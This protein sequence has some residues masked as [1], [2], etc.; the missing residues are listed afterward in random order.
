MARR[1]IAVTP[2]EIASLVVTVYDTATALRRLG[3]AEA[4]VEGQ[5]QARWQVINVAAAGTWTVPQIARR[6]G[7]QRQS[8][9]RIVDRLHDDG[10]VRLD[11]NPDHATSPIVHPTERGAAVLSNIN[12]VAD[13]WHRAIAAAADPA[14]VR[15]TAQFLAWLAAS[16][17]PADPTPAPDAHG[18]VSPP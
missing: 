5:T 14:D 6:L 11:P 1:V 8:V 13:R 7:V 10:L 16:A 9:Q 4:G 2:D 3:D 18:D 15:T 17:S 12:A